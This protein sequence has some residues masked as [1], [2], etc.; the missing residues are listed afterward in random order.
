MVFDSLCYVVVLCY[1]EV[2]GVGSG[3]TNWLMGTKVM[4]GVSACG[5]M[6]ISLGRVCVIC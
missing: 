4:A 1:G 5:G 6:G 3:L 2:G